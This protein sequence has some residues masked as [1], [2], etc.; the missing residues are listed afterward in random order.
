MDFD[1]RPDE[2][3]R[4]QKARENAGYETARAACDA[5]G[6][7]YDTYIQHERGERGLSR[8]A[9]RYADAFGVR[10]AWLLTGEDDPAR[11]LME[12]DVR[13]NIGAGGSIESASEQTHDHEPLRRVTV[14]F[15]VPDDAIAFQVLGESMWPRYDPGD[16]I[17]CSRFGE[18]SHTVIGF[19][20]AVEA[21]DGNRYLKRV[22]KGSAPHLFHLESH[23][24]PLMPDVSV[25]SFARVLATIPASE[26]N[27]VTR[28]VRRA[29]AK[30]IKTGAS[31]RGG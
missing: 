21:D 31:S 25:R 3:I 16:I 13:G 17:I 7:T 30:Q 19:I 22:L 24:A 5:F 9:K 12:I 27:E 10:V 2:A 20:A 6:F 11:P 15:P 4:L 29:V 8:A 28:A 23:N 1:D 14:P 18:P 26:V